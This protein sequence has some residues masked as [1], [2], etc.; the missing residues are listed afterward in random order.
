M[1]RVRAGRARTGWAAA[2][3]QERRVRMAGRAGMPVSRSRSR[4]AAAA[5]GLSHV[6]RRGRVK[7]VDVGDKPV[8][9]REAIARGM[10][11]MSREALR[12]IRRGAVKK[13]DPLQAA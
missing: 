12:L 5:P 11:T 1:S 6:D 8:T 2:P 9:T 7:M 13:G 4:R 3:L 10:I